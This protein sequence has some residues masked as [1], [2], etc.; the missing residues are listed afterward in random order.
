[1]FSNIPPYDGDPILSL[2]ETYAL[3]PRADRVNLSIGFYYDEDGRLPVLRSV[4]DAH[5]ALGTTHLGRGYLPM[6][7][8]PAYCSAVRPLVF[9]DDC[10]ACVDGRVATIQ[11]LGGSGAL[12]VGA[13]FLFSAW[14]RSRVCISD[15]TWDNHR[16]I[17]EGAGFEV[18]AY[19]YF[20]SATGAVDFAGMIAF[21]GALPA[22]SIVVLHPCCHNPT[23]AD[24]TPAQWDELIALMAARRLIAFFDMA[25]QGFARG[26]DEDRYAVRAAADA[27]MSF[28][29]SQ[30]FS[31]TFALYAQRCGSLSVV[32]ASSEEAQRSLGHLQRMVRRNYSSPPSYGSRLIEHV[33]SDDSLRTAWFDEVAGMRARMARMRGRLHEALTADAKDGDWGFL[34]Q[35]NGMFSYAPA[36]GRHAPAL[37][38]DFGV[39]ILESG[40]IC[41]AGLTSG[42]VAH[43]ARA[44]AEVASAG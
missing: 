37:R 44:F 32:C 34:L 41:I 3:D 11:T 12:K 13:D 43:V 30:S 10:E 19:P 5:S 15:P 6:S 25:Y 1:M 28:V 20:D 17:F 23:G 9:G 29:V 36:L 40:R 35:Q 16:A 21:I 26:I 2:Q 18:E 4:L 22:H 24:P 7:G 33:L 42:N 14:P 8:D 39:Y 27:G 38:N 31:K